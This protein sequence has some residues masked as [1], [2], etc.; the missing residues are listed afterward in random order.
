MIIYFVFLVRFGPVNGTWYQQKPYL[1][2]LLINELKCK[3]AYKNTMTDICSTIKIKVNTSNKS[4]L[5]K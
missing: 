1:K 4:E 3:E 5:K 2:F